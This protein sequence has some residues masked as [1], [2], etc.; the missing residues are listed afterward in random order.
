MTRMILALCLLLCATGCATREVADLEYVHSPGSPP[1]PGTV[2]VSSSDVHRDVAYAWLRMYGYKQAPIASEATYVVDID[3]YYPYLVCDPNVSGDGA[4]ASGPP[5]CHLEPNPGL[6]MIMRRRGASMFEPPLV[7]IKAESFTRSDDLP[8][9]DLLLELIFANFPG[10]EGESKN[11]FLEKSGDL[12]CVVRK[13]FFFTTT[14]YHCRAP[15]APPGVVTSA[16]N[17]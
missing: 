4:L 10:I 3:V 11:L 5:I 1:A 2:E 6:D 8:H 13:V 14:V 9:R 7:E 17:S 16:P 12:L 15:D